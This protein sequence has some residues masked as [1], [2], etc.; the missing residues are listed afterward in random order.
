MKM[1]IAVVAFIAL[2]GCSVSGLQEKKPLFVGET[3][4]AAGIVARCLGPK[5]QDINPSTSVTET[6]NGY[7]VLVSDSSLGALVLATIVGKNGGSSATVQASSA[8]GSAKA[9]VQAAKDCM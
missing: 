8:F 9:F 7:R 5:W 6:E 4:K 2:T 3:V 1:K